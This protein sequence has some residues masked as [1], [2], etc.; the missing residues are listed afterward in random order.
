MKVPLALA[1]LSN[2][3]SRIGDDVSK[4]ISAT[5]DAASNLASLNRQVHSDNFKSAR[6]YS[7][8][9]T[10]AKEVLYANI[11]WLSMQLGQVEGVLDSMDDRV[12]EAPKSDTKAAA[13][14]KLIRYARSVVDGKDEKGGPAYVSLEDLA[15]AVRE[16]EE[17]VKP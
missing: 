10:C 1:Q 9:V 4:A 3:L 14:A 16:A 11:D 15:F 8:S 7:A 12:K 13:I 6:I 2:D 5:S 17:A